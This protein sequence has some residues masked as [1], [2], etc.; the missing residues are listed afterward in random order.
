MRYFNGTARR[1]I[2]VRKSLQTSESLK[3]RVHLLCLVCEANLGRPVQIQ[4]NTSLQG[5]DG[6][7]GGAATDGKTIYLPDA[8]PDLGLYKLMALHQSM[9]PDTLAILSQNGATPP[10][11]GQVHRETDRRLLE[12]FPMLGNEMRRQAPDASP[13]EDSQEPAPG[14]TPLP[15]WGDILPDL[16]RQTE[17]TVARLQE[18]AATHIGCGPE[19]VEGIVTSL[20]AK[21]QREDASLW[22]TLRCIL[23]TSEM[24]A[25]AC[26]APPA[27]AQVF[28]YDEW[29]KTLS[30]YKKNWSRVLQQKLPEDPNGFGREVRARLGG[31]IALVKKRFL[32]LKPATF[33][34]LRGQRSGDNLDVDALVQ[35]VVDMRAGSFLEENVYVRR[36]KTVRNVA[37][38]FL[39]DT[40]ASTEEAVAGRRVIDIQKDAA[41]LMSEALTALGDQHA[42]FGFNSDGRFQ[43]NL[44]A[45]KE[46]HEPGGRNVGRRLGNLQPDGLTRLG[47]A[48]RHAVS[49]L[50]AVEASVKLLVVLTDGRPYDLDYGDLDYAVA[51]SKKAVL[52]ARK[53]KINPFIITSDPEG[54]GYL[55]QITRL[56]QSI[57]L[58]R[59]EMLPSLLPTIYKRL[60]G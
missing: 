34:K 56:T 13:W 54:A 30:A 8:A 27:D 11:P 40:S 4:S 18:K 32:L 7:T 26:L 42:I 43:V 41:F 19:I 9:I 31:L 15:W 46:F 1:A 50:S 14:E 25:S 5:I 3:R 57:V 2:K 52:E 55:A 24:G 49:K 60:T 51:D 20:I 10:F 28:Y 44:Q 29:D 33:Q 48:L 22:E 59:V 47:A 53:L 23:N 36:D 58:P 37:V 16:I 39:L 17:C 12:R 6:F 21:G 45:V 38:L 35:A